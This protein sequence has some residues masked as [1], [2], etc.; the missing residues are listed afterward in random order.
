MSALSILVPFRSSD[1]HRIRVWNYLRPKYEALPDVELCVASDGGREGEPFSFSRAVNAARRMATSDR[2]MTVGADQYPP[3]P[4]QLGRIHRALSERT[5]TMAYRDRICYD[6]AQT[7]RILA[8][9][10]VDEPPRGEFLGTCWGVIALHSYVWDDIRGFDERFVGWGHED[11]TVQY[12]LQKL[13][14]DGEPDGEGTQYALWH[15]FAGHDEQAKARNLETSRNLGLFY[16]HIQAWRDGRLR[17][18]IEGRGK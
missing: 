4:Q 12:V 9:E 2:L 8:G 5:W 7:G 1:P 16:E 11:A 10:V 18:Y 15:E 13:Y 6:Q 3:S 14:P 17:E